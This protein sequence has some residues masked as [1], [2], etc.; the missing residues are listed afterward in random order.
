MFI[1]VTYT[2][3]E[4]VSIKIKKPCSSVSNHRTSSTRSIK[5]LATNVSNVDTKVEYDEKDNSFRASVLRRSTA[6]SNYNTNMINVYNKRIAHKR[7][8]KNNTINKF[9]FTIII[10]S[11][12][13]VFFCFQLPVRIFLCWSYL[14]HYLLKFVWNEGLIIDDSNVNIIHLI[15]HITSLVYFLHCI[16]NPIIYNVVSNKFRKAFIQ[17]LGINN[18]NKRLK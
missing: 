2:I 18:N 1:T 17:F 10:S 16:S 12:T 13:I 8:F 5:S 14:N 6:M 7:Q 15:S 11:I 9:K 4:N 3:K